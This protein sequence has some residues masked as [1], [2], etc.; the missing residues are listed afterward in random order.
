MMERRD[1]R[2]EAIRIREK[3]LKK[4]EQKQKYGEKKNKYRL[5]KKMKVIER[6]TE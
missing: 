1:K 2:K 6:N 3:N 4:V 5:V